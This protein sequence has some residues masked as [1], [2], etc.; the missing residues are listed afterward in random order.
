[1]RTFRDAHAIS[2]FAALKPTIMAAPA[3][4]WAVS[5]ATT[6]SV[7]T[8]SPSARNGSMT[9]CPVAVSAASTDRVRSARHETVSINFTPRRNSRMRRVS[10]IEATCLQRVHLGVASAV[11]DQLVVGAVLHD[12][13][14]L[15]DHDAIRASNR[16]EPV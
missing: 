3:T 11:A 9:Y 7:S 2:R 13:A 8:F 5:W 6:P 15:D 1:M 10:G 12:D 4:A 16:R 14:V